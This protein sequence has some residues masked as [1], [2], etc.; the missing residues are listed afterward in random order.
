MLIVQ[1]TTKRCNLLWG[2]PVN[3]WHQYIFLRPFFLSDRS[4]PHWYKSALFNELYFIS[5]GGTIWVES[6]EEFPNGVRH[7]HCW[8]HDLV[9]EYG[10]FGYLEGKCKT[11]LVLSMNLQKLHLS[12]LNLSRQLMQLIEEWAILFHVSKL[13]SPRMGNGVPHKNRGSLQLASE[14]ANIWGILRGKWQV[15]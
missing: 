15:E 14:C 3:V 1:S 4:L 2:L 11:E 12:Q 6:N 5:D 9:R 13:C 10:R 8:S 7:K